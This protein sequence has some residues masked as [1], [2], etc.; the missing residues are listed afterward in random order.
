[1]KH[2]IR[3]LWA[4]ASTSV[5]LAVG[6]SGCAFPGLTS[7]PHPRGITSA[8]GR[9]A[10]GPTGPQGLTG[11]PGATGPTGATG[12]EGD[13]G[14]SGPQGL[15]G[16]R[17]LTGVTGASGPMGPTGATG[18]QGLAGTNGTAV[19][20]GSGQ[21]NS[22][23]GGVGDF[24]VETSNDTL[25]GP[26]TANGGWVLGGVSLIGATGATGTT[27]VAGP[28]GMQGPMG[29]TG[30]QGPQGPMGPTGAAGAAGATGLT[31]PGYAFVTATGSTG[32]T[33]GVGRTYWVDV[34]VTVTS[35]AS[36]LTGSCGVGEF[37]VGI[38][39]TVFY[40]SINWPAFAGT[41]APG[42]SIAGVVSLPSS[43]P[44]PTPLHVQCMTNTGTPIT[45]NS[46]RWYMSPVQVAP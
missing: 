45:V 2:R 34:E 12:A 43:G 3:P 9:G 10:T 19:L 33:P 20:S 44:A 22:T 6:V 21:P 7:A 32:P 37:P 27:G 36:P 38:V 29:V 15:Q 1:M 40:G 39:Q 25:W 26:K 41:A 13:A 35:G 5:L 18:L 16:L 8:G 42:F 31:G 17:G 30:P 24:Y 46:V 14:L 28:Q 23:L 11:P 4:L